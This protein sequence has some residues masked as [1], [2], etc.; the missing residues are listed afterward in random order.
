MAV[1]VNPFT[2]GG[3]GG[4][5]KIRWYQDVVAPSTRMTSGTSSAFPWVVPGGDSL[6]LDVV[7]EVAALA[8][9]A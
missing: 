9:G 4:S 2:S 6:R 5:D 3:C 1:I 7:V 8:V